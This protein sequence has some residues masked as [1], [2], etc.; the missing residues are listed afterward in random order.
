MRRSSDQ[1]FDSRDFSGRSKVNFH[2]S[3]SIRYGKLKS[4]SQKEKREKQRQSKGASRIF[5]RGGRGV[6]I[7]NQTDHKLFIYIFL[8]F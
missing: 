2:H 3:P 1:I 6:Q 7:L 5:V 8:R 4:Y